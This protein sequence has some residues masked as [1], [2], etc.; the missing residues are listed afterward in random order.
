MRVEGEQIGGLE[1]RL[2]PAGRDYDAT[3]GRSNADAGATM[4]RAEDW[5]HILWA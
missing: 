1:T 4:G 5:R 2:R 3:S